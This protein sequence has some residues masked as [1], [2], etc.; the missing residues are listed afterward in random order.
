M[1]KAQ[2]LSIVIIAN[3]VAIVNDFSVN[4]TFF[5]SFFCQY[6]NC[7]V[8]CCPK[9]MEFENRINFLSSFFDSFFIK[10]NRFS[11]KYTC[12][13]RYNNLLNIENAS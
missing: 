10:D 2:G 8:T 6:E 1:S 9:K 3:N 12:L 11:I 5:F 4:P 7:N 13:L